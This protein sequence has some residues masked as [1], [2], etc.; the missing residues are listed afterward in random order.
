MVLND[1]CEFIVDCPHSTAPDEGE[2]YPIIRTP[3]VGRGRLILDGVQRVSKATYDKRNIRAVPQK[4]DIIF[5]REAPAGNAAI[6]RAG[7]E[8]CLGQ[9]TVLIRPDKKKVCPQFLAYYILAPKQQYELLGTANGATVAH[10][11]IP[12][13]RNMPVNL[14]KIEIQE[15]IAEILSSYDDLIENNKKQIKL[16]E[17]AA[18]RLYREWFVD[19]HFPRYE[20]TEIIDGVPEGW[21]RKRLVDIA[22]I[23]YG[24]AFDG[25]K[26]NDMKKGI[27]IVRIRNIPAGITSDYTTEETEEKYLIGNGDII[28]GMDGEFHINSWS[29]DNAYL[30]QRTCCFRPKKKEMQGWLLWA[31]RKPIKYYEKTIVGATV[32]HLGK[33]HIDAIDLLVGPDELYVPFQNYFDKRQSLLNQNVLLL[34][35][36]DRLLPRLMSGEV[37]E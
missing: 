26:F 8:V 24:Y 11:N 3:N 2:G 1:I 30:V 31:I 34:E 28:V 37:E 25:S 16:L 13:I 20:N 32:S 36:R 6:I 14:P 22:D 18:E 27:P 5:A 21:K 33:K 9:R 15:R 10:V 23:Q 35:A 29:G 19:L 12:I 17:E 4:D 7:Q